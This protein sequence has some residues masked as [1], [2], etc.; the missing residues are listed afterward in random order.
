MKV[1]MEDTF[2]LP[3][4]PVKRGAASGRRRGAPG[5]LP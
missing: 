3:G 5:T 4:A 2:G 1:V